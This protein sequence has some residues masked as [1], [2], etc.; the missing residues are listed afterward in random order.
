MAKAVQGQSYS[1]TATGTPTVIAGPND[2]RRVFTIIN[3]DPTNDIWVGFG[4]NGASPVGHF[5]VK[6]NFGSLIE[7]PVTGAP[8]VS[9]ADVTVVAVGGTPQ[10]V[11]MED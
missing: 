9:R 8:C 10:F 11:Y 6:A 7:G 5:R 3:N 1:L 2:N 4:L